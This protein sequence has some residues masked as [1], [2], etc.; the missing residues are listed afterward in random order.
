MCYPVLPWAMPHD[1]FAI[2][3]IGHEKE[4]CCILMYGC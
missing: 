1:K 2:W 4:K 3:E